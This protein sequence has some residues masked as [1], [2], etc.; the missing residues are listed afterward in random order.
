MVEGGGRGAGVWE[1]IVR[2]F[3]EVMYTLLYSKW[4]IKDYC[5]AQRTLFNVMWQP[6]WKGLWGRMDICIYMCRCICM[7][8]QVFRNL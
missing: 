1:R 7:A 5:I 6:G 4:I 2:K 3:G 8:E